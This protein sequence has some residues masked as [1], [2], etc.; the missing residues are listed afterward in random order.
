MLNA[1]HY[2][3]RRSRSIPGAYGRLKDLFVSVDAGP[4][5]FVGGATLRLG[6]AERAQAGTAACSK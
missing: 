1:K 5:L 4:L 2:H 3:A 6:G